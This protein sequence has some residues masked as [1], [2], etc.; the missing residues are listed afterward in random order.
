VAIHARFVRFDI[1]LVLVV[2]IFAPVVRATTII[3]AKALVICRA[4]DFLSTFF[5]LHR[6]HSSI[7]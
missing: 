1:G 6:T 7:I 2:S 3:V 5:A 4:S